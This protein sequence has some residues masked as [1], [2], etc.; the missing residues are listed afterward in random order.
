MTWP[1]ATWPLAREISVGRAPDTR[2]KA[3]GPTVG[4]AKA[5]PSDT[6][7]WPSALRERSLWVCVRKK[8]L[9]RAT[10]GTVERSSDEFAVVL[11]GPYYRLQKSTNGAR[12]TMPSSEELEG[13]P[14][15]L[16]SLRESEREAKERRKPSRRWQSREIGG[17]SSSV[18]ALT[19]CASTSMKTFVDGR[20]PGPGKLRA[21]TC[22]VWQRSWPLASCP[23][24]ERRGALRGVTEGVRDRL[25][26]LRVVENAAARW[27]CL[28]A[29]PGRLRVQRRRFVGK[30]VEV[31]H[32]PSSAR[33]PGAGSPRGGLALP[34]S[35]CFGVF[36]GAVGGERSSWRKLRARE[37][38]GPRVLVSFVGCRGR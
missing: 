12:L 16:A 15:G 36:L 33:P 10:A 11:A 6:L 14:V 8:L 31:G 38:S 19:A 5:S 4:F 30:Q 1:C 7:T 28:R 24:F 2:A 21:L 32:A 23:S 13:S 9:R 27:C 29:A 18:N 26:A 17:G 37:S 35:T 22:T 20:R 34:S 3:R 25:P